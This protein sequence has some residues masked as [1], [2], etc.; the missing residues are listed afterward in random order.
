MFVTKW[1]KTLEKVKKLLFNANIERNKWLEPINLFYFYH[2]FPRI[3]K[4]Q[5]FIPSKFYLLY[6]RWSY[7]HFL[8]YENFLQKLASFRRRSSAATSLIGRSTD[9]HSRNQVWKLGFVTAQAIQLPGAYLEGKKWLLD[10]D[11]H[12]L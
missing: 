11:Y 4:H 3:W 7:L 12:F 2:Q 5:Y 6:M 10:L 1:L 9:T 8:S